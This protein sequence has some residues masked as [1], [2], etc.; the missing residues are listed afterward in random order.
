MTQVGLTALFAIVLSGAVCSCAKWLAPSKR[1]N[2][3]G[4]PL[5]LPYAGLAFALAFASSL[6]AVVRDD[7]RATAAAVAYATLF[8]FLA[9]AVSER[10]PVTVGRPL[11]TVALA[12]GAVF[13]VTHGIV[14][15]HAKLPFGSVLALGHGG[16]W[17]TG[18]WVFLVALLVTLS[19]R[20][21]ALVPGIAVFSSFT[22]CCVAWIAGSAAISASQAGLLGLSAAGAA[23]PVL[24]FCNPPSVIRFGMGGGMAV[25]LAVGCVSAMGAVK[26]SAF[27]AVATPVLCLGAPLLGAAMTLAANR[28]RTLGTVLLEA[29][30]VSFVGV[31]VRRGM[32]A[33]QAVAFL[34]AWHVYLCFIAILLAIGIRQSWML[35]SI[36]LLVLGGTGLLAFGL[37]FQIVYG[38]RTEAAAGAIDAINLLGVRIDRTSFRDAVDRVMLWSERST[39]H[40][41]VTA[42][43]TLVDRASREPALREVLAKAA[44]V[45]PDGAGV[46]FSA[47]VLGAPFDE[48]VSGVDLV[49]R[50]CAEAAERG[51]P[52]Y[53]LGAEPGV[54]R[55]AGERLRVRR[56][57]L[58]IA[59]VRHGYFE[60]DEEPA[61]V[62][63]IAGSGARI[64][65]VGLG[66]PRQEEFIDRNRDWL[67]VGV[68]IGVGGTFDVLSGKIRR[69]PEWMQR[70][71][72]EWLWR[73]A[74]DPKRLPRLIALPRF[75]LRV[76]VHTIRSRRREGGRIG[77]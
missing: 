18:G 11:R 55:E 77:G 74:K 44:L 67:G 8:A 15:T 29:E 73:A 39:L 19:S 1:Y 31:L 21:E 7:W 56:P 53:L 42:D 2:A 22:L 49:D 57:H 33:R 38:W 47:R 46:L 48:R 54:A 25:G 3:D 32:T 10:L 76:M 23:L 60:P 36:L 64:A 71:G 17:L 5:G 59:G 66:V 68:A 69:A 34:L 14:I 16:P 70:V 26:H 52:I 41:V 37:T 43:A 35:K 6:L 51:V 63:E 28:G 61:V 9:G 27:L 12:V 62:D 30:R 45:T 40:H 72:L 50:V 24:R 75:V 65:L 4:A 20:G 13:V 58:R